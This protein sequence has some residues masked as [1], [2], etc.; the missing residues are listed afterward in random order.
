MAARKKKKPL[1]KFPKR[2]QKKLVVMFAVISMMLIGLV[3]RL[4]YIEQGNGI[5]D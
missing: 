2:M 1:L 5:G 3:A 4:M